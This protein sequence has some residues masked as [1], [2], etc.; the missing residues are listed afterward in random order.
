MHAPTDLRLFAP[1][2]LEWLVARHATLYRESDGFDDSFATLVREIL[3]GFVA[4]HD[5]ARERGWIAEAPDGRL[6]SIFCVA[7]EEPDTAKL[8]LFF[9]E[10]RARGQG[11][12]RHM[13]DT[14][15]GFAAARGYRRMTLGTHESHAAACRLYAR[16]G[17]VLADSRPVVSF[18]RNLVEQHWRI[19][20]PA[21]GISPVRPLALRGGD[22]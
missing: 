16:T 10:P 1:E 14:C 18:G 8:R 17:F 12:G 5:P 19:D 20:L 2:D 4:H 15:L 21:T 7:A 22:G 9:L 11:L 13:L 6:G 3:E